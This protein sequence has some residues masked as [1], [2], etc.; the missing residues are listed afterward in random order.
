MKFYSILVIISLVCA[1]SFAAEKKVKFRK[2]QSVDFEEASVDGLARKPTGAY[3]VQKR[4]V[5]FMPLY[6]VRQK[7]DD[8][9]MESI[10]YLR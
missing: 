3:L 6:K 9:I 8:N 7:F 1:H 4:G 10:E 2:T 5:D